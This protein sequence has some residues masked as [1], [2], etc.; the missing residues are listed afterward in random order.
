VRTAF[1][2]AM[3]RVARVFPHFRGKT[4][5]LLLLAKL[6]GLEGRHI[7]VRTTLRRPTSFEVELDLHAW[8]QRVAF[9]TGAYEADTVEFLVDM[10]RRTGRDGW[11]LDIG[12]NV[13][14][15]A[16]PFAKTTQQRVVAFEAVPDNVTALRNNVTRNGLDARIAIHP[17]ALG[18]TSG[19]AQIQVEGDLHAGEGTG[20]ANILPEGSTYECV[21]QEIEVR[22][23]DEL[24]DL[25]R[26]CSLIKIDTDGYDLK[27][28]QGAVRFLERER[29]VIFGEFAE[30]CL[31]WHQQSVTGVVRFADAHRYDVWMRVHPGWEFRRYTAGTPF[32][33]DLLL[34][35][36]EMPFR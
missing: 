3:V 7:R 28:L 34:V 35:P 19:V 33:Q 11:L 2:L 23:L 24:T 18:A 13:G 32:S 36:R 30:H 9:L 16:I 1:F 27:I 6:L 25:P 20:T 21:R 14:L 29:P 12:A 8:A 17:F 22:T 10:H 4:R 26:G 5:L 31:N 15:I